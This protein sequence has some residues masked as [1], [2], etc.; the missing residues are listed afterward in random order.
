M[1]AIVGYY[2]KAA[3]VR[4]ETI[5]RALDA[6]AH[7]GPDDRQT[8]IDASGRIGLAHARL[9]IIDVEGGRQPLHSEDGAIHAAVN[10]EFYGFEPI[11]AELIARGHRF[12]TRSDSEIVVHLYEEHGDDCV[13]HL[14]GEFSVVL[15]DARARRLIAVRD[16]FGIKPL[17]YSDT[18]GSLILASEIKGILAA[19]HPARWDLESVHQALFLFVGQDRTLFRDIRQVPPGAML[20]ADD[21][22]VRMRRYWDLCYPRGGGAPIAESTATDCVRQLVSEA[23][24]IRLRADVPVS[25]FLSGGLDSSAVFGLAAA[26]T[27][28]LRAFTVAFDEDAYDE[29]AIARVTAAHHGVQLAVVHASSDEMAR[30]FTGAVRAAETL[31]V[32]WHGVARYQLCR[33][34]RAAGFKVALAGEGGDELFAGYLQLR[35]DASSEHDGGAATYPELQDVRARLGYVPCWMRHVAEGRRVCRIV[36]AEDFMQRFSDRNPYTELVAGMD[37]EQL[38]GRDRLHQSSYLWIRSVLANYI[39]FAERLEMAHAVE[40]RLPLLDHVL[41]EYTRE[42]PRELMLKG[43]SEKYVL[44][45]AARPVLT[46]QVYRRAKH[47][48]FA[49]PASNDGAEPQYRLLT[50]ILTREALEALSFVDADAVGALLRALPRLPEHRRIAIDSVLLMLACASV[51]QRE[52]GVGD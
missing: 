20:I 28:S 2:S 4:L 45:Q 27:T 15:W 49:P 9:G 25:A 19:G 46:E 8:W 24:R 26:Q 38:A 34:I 30:H 44:R 12:A 41:F 39:L 7:R 16:R 40:T 37:A 42:L 47:P 36:L 13:R 3:P 48:F 23:V 31:G 35:Q 18:A 5:E 33:G 21:A 29:T 32:N 10:G 6:V 22:G 43:A 50:D 52:F 51:L 17:F 11:R 14:R 1:C